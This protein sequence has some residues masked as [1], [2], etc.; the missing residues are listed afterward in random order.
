[1]SCR[2][3]ARLLTG[4]F[5]SM[6]RTSMPRLPS[7]CVRMSTICLSWNSAG[8]L[9]LT[10]ISFS[11]SVKVAPVSL[12]SKRCVSSR[13]AWSTALVSSWASSSETVS[14]EGMQVLSGAQDLFELARNL[15]PD[16]AAHEFHDDGR[17]APGVVDAEPELAEAPDNGADQ[18]GVAAHRTG[19]AA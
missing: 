2:A 13:F 12:K 19:E 17:E 10:V 6:Q 3:S 14:N 18:R 15:G 4:S 7:R 1:M 8:A 9:R 16:P 5:F 11:L